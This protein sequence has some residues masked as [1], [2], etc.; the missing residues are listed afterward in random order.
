MQP[1]LKKCKVNS[2]EYCVTS[3]DTK[4]LEQEAFE[5]GEE[6]SQFLIARYVKIPLF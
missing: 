4:L 6:V 3:G 1:L 5:A 2:Y